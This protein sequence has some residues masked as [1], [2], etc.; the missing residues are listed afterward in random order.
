[1]ADGDMAR[2][3]TIADDE[4]RRIAATGDPVAQIH[5]DITGHAVRLHIPLRDAVQIRDVAKAL[6]ILA[7]TL[8]IEA[9]SRDET[10]RVLFRAKAAIL[11]CNRLIGG[12][13]GR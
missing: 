13:K 2:R 7:S 1:M 9:Q 4:M 3:P 5:R 6:R 10:W 11:M 8:D 12:R